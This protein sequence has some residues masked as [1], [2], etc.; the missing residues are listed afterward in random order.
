LTDAARFLR[1]RTDADTE[2]RQSEFNAH[3]YVGYL[4]YLGERAAHTG[5]YIFRPGGRS[6]RARIP[7]SILR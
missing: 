3:R 4:T 2:L 7:A 1:V 6:T 5:V